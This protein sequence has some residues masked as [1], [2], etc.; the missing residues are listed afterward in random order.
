[1]G[2]VAMAKRHGGLDACGRMVAISCCPR[3]AS[4]DLRTPGFA[5]G[6]VPETDNLGDW[7]CRTCGLR[8]IP[9]EFDDEASYRAYRDERTSDVNGQEG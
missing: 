9:I 6:L 4:R 8:A 3:C 7:V 1:M 2:F 5:D